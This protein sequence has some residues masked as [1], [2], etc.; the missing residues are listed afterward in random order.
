MRVM[1]FDPGLSQAGTVTVEITRHTEAEVIHAP[2]ETLLARR[3]LTFA[4]AP[5]DQGR[6][7][8]A[9]ED[10]GRTA[11]LVAPGDLAVE[12]LRIPGRGGLGIRADQV[13]VIERQG[14]CGHG[15]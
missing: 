10:L 5:D 8:H 1:G 3:M 9:H 2:L 4:L 15:R 11:A 7:P 13:N 12:V 14:V 6:I